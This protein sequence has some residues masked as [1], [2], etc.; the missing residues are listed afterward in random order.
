MRRPD[1]LEHGRNFLNQRANAG[2]RSDNFGLQI[3]LGRC[4]HSRRSAEA[5]PQI[6]IIAHL[7]HDQ[8]SNIDRRSTDGRGL[9]VFSIV[10][11]SY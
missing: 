2:T 1:Y 8:G 4:G 5:H 9:P 11:A 6:L 7:D 10:S 3:I